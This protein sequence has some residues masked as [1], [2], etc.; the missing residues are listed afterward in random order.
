MNFQLCI[1]LYAV[2]LVLV[3]CDS[4]NTFVSYDYAVEG[5]LLHLL[6]SLSGTM[7]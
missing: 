5:I 2:I 3:L 6:I 1:C 7:S 4:I